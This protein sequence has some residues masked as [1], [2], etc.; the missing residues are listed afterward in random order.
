MNDSNILIIEDDASTRELLFAILSG[1]GYSNISLASDGDKGSTLIYAMK[2]DLVL[3]D[4]DLPGISGVDICR[5]MRSND[6]TARIPVIMLTGHN[7]E[8]EIAK[9]L[10]V[11]ANDYVTK[12]FSATVL[13][14]RIRTQLRSLKTS[15]EANERVIY[16]DL[17]LSES[18][19]VIT[20]KETPLDLT[21]GEF[22]LLKLFIC[23]PGR[24]FSRAQII[25]LIRGDD[26]IATERSIDVQVAMLRK[27]LGTTGSVIESVRGV[28][29]RMKSLLS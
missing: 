4:L 3:L 23:N 15:V 11:G 6:A 12:P 13:L 20:L 5:L 29:Y 9:G 8:D 1:A 14:A 21:A 19:H 28:G 26:Y 16:G 24:V 10:D 27:K 25:K 17:K 18:T 2:P 22:D 7:D